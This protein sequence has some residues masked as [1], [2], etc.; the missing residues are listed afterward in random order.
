VQRYTDSPRAPTALYR[1]GLMAEQEGDIDQARV[2]YE[3]VVTGYP[4]SDAAEL[5]RAKLNRNR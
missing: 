5:A 1:L 3:R 2:Y 4:R